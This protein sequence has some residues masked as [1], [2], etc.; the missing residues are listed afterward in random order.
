MD[1]RI[2]T[3]KLSSLVSCCPSKRTALTCSSEKGGRLAFLLKRKEKFVLEAF[4]SLARVLS[5]QALSWSLIVEDF[6]SQ[7]HH[8]LKN[9]IFKKTDKVYK[10]KRPVRHGHQ[11]SSPNISSNRLSFVIRK[12]EMS[13]PNEGFDGDTPICKPKGRRLGS[14]EVPLKDTC[15]KRTASQ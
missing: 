4:C 9:K 3:C 14:L 1:T 8:K 6:Q 11:G 10:E 12:P 15:F 5:S 2:P 7:N 13:C